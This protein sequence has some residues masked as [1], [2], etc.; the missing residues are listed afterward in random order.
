MLCLQTYLDR[1]YFGRCSN[2]LPLFFTKI[3]NANN[4]NVIEID[5][6]GKL[7]P[8]DLKNNYLMSCF[9]LIL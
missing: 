3:Y 7:V 4:R 1:G 2:Y 6:D 9:M 8:S 5:S